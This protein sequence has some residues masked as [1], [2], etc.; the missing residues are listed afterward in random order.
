MAKLPK[1]VFLSYASQDAEAAKRICE[2]Q[3]A[4]DA[5]VW[6]DQSEV[7]GGEGTPGT[8][9]SAKRSVETKAL[10]KPSAHAQIEFA[11]EQ[12]LVAGRPL[13]RDP[14]NQALAQINGLTRLLRD[15]TGKA[16][17]VRGVVVFPGWFVER[18]AAAKP[19]LICLPK[20]KALAGFLHQEPERLPATDVSLASFHL[21]RFTGG[22]PAA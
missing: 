14:V 16:F 12:A 15:S 7:W 17:P 2:A 4:A 18:S 10:S 20:P 8:R 11:G 13:D 19:S 3:M 5:V 9:R 6:F 1:A 21:S 22:A